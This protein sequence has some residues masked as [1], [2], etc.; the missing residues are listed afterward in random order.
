MHKTDKKLRL[1]RETLRRLGNQDLGRVQ[2]AAIFGGYCS[3]PLPLNKNSCST[4]VD[5]GCD[6]CTLSSACV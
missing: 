1:R 3:M 5:T 4:T 6:G 2:G